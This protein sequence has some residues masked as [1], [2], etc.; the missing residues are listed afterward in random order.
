MNSHQT[1]N[2]LLDY[3]SPFKLTDKEFIYKDGTK[4]MRRDDLY[5]VFLIEQMEITKRAFGIMLERNA[6]NRSQ[7]KII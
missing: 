5:T 7:R 6:T 4:K 3:Y 1:K 2:F